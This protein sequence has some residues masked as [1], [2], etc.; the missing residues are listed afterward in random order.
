[1]GPTT[2]LY[3][4]ISATSLDPSRFRGI[5]AA[6]VGFA[7][8]LL[9]LRGVVS[10]PWA[11][12]LDVI[13]QSVDGTRCFR[14][15]EFPDGVLAMTLGQNAG[16]CGAIRRLRRAVG[17]VDD[18]E[19]MP[20]YFINVLHR[21]DF[22]E[23]RHERPILGFYTMSNS[24]LVRERL[25]LCGGDVRALLALLEGMDPPCLDRAE[26][27]GASPFTGCFKEGGML[28]FHE[29]TGIRLNRIR[30]PTDRDRRESLQQAERLSTQWKG[31]RRAALKFL[32][33]SPQLATEWA[34][35]LKVLELRQVEEGDR[36]QRLLLFIEQNCTRDLSVAEI[37]A[38][39][40]MSPSRLYELFR[41]R[42]GTSPMS[43]A[44]ER[45]MD[46]AERLLVGTTLSMGEISDRCGFA[47]QASL[48]HSLR[49]RRGLS[50][51]ALRKSLRC[52]LVPPS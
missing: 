43:F 39:F 37:A 21:G 6:N 52:G 33:M 12:G 46:L 34:T 19:P 23:S 11:A 27:A 20:G 42:L 32:G 50:P 22:P 17:K 15:D 24:V 38:A 18:L 10:S 26:Q 25:A 40:R 4:E 47:D 35:A 16:N 51:T 41:E 1:M 5:W 29:Q 31:A 8:H 49:R 13:G 7:P 2:K 48:S 3:P 36:L 9:G 45:R 44:H 14:I 30:V 28:Q